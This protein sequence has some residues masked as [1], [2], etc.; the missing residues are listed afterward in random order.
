MLWLLIVPTL[1]GIHD[2]SRLFVNVVEL[3]L[4]FTYAVTILRKHM[5]ASSGT[6]GNINVYIL[7]Q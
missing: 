2:I 5:M 3:R 7:N 6:E 4:S 1:H